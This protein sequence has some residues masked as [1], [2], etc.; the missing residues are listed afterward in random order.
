VDV[1]DVYCHLIAGI[2]YIGRVAAI[3]W[4]HAVNEDNLGTEGHKP[5]SQR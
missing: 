4:D 2:V 1:A 3:L 5:S